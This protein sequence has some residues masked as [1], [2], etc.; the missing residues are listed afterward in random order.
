VIADKLHARK[1]EYEYEKMLILAGG[2]R[3]WPDFTLKVPKSG[4]TLYWEHLGMLGDAAYRRKW[5]TKL[6]L[7]FRSGIV[8][9]GPDGDPEGSLIISRDDPAGGI[10]SA[11]IGKLLDDI[12]RAA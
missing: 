2:A 6:D 9:L 5:I 1:I 10:D 8:P 3:R 11:A 7:Y 4:K 12:V